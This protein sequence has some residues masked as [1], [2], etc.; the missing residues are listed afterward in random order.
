MKNKF[1]P[2]YFKNLKQIDLI[3]D[4]DDDVTEVRS[5]LA[6]EYYLVYSTTT[7]EQVD[8]LNNRLYDRLDFKQSIGEEWNNVFKNALKLRY[9]YPGVFEESQIFAIAPDWNSESVKITN[10]EEGPDY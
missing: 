10:N 9:D 6:I 1:K 7:D 4:Q 8:C 2:N 5:D 3:D